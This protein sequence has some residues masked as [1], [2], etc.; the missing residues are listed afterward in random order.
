MGAV[1]FG[2]QANEKESFAMMDRAVDAGI[3]LLRHRRRCIRCRR[4]RRSPASAE[5]IVGRWLKGEPHGEIILATKV[6]GPGR[7]GWFRPPVRNGFTALDRQSNQCGPARTACVVFADGLHRPV[8]DAYGRMRGARQEDIL[9]AL[10]ELVQ[11][12]K[13]RGHAVRATRQA[14]A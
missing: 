5:E 11:Q 2:L 14:G 6:A 7:Q 10:T 3:E 1:A 13:V 4:A 12:G 8:S 9:E